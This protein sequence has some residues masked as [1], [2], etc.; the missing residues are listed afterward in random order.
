MK[1][2][3]DIKLKELNCDTEDTEKFEEIMHIFDNYSDLVLEAMSQV[4]EILDTNYSKTDIDNVVE[5]YGHL[6]LEEKNKLKCLLYKYEDL[7]DGTLG[8]W[9]TEPVKLDLKPDAAPFYT[10][11][12]QIPRVHEQTL[13]KEVER[14]IQLGVLKKCID[15]E[16][17]SPA[18]I[19]PKSDK[20]MQ[21]VTNFRKLNSM[22][23]RKPYLLPKI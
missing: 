9:N 14:L 17:G 8:T 18:F 7:F 22:I 3:A 2:A 23:K 4:T 10:H 12:Y 20:T 21:F 16:W 1:S 13:R 11:P 5:E 6:S 19:I 15:S